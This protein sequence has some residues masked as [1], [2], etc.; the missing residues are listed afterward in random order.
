[1]VKSTHECSYEILPPFSRQIRL[2]FLK[3]SVKVMELFQNHFRGG[4]KSVFGKTV[5]L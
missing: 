1:M 4:C 3:Y 5:Y 2:L